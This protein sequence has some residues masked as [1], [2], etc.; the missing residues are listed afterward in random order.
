MSRENEKKY[1]MRNFN[2]VK[3]KSVVEIKDETEKEYINPLVSDFLYSLKDNL[4]LNS[5]SSININNPNDTLKILKEVKK[6]VERERKKI[7]TLL[8]LQKGLIKEPIMIQ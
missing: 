2:L 7:P 5:L 8:N 4:N 6:N 3:K 1:F